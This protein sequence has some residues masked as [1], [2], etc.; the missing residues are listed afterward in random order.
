MAPLTP[1]S[2]F[3]ELMNFPSIIKDEN[4]RL[5]PVNIILIQVSVKI[6]SQVRC[7]AQT[8]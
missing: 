3:F 7:I 4:K 2:D 8:L 1:L 6:I 5:L